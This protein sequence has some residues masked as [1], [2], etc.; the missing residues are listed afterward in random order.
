M[1]GTSE[2][3]SPVGCDLFL[4][5][6]RQYFLLL[7]STS[8]ASAMLNLLILQWP[9]FQCCRVVSGGQCAESLLRFVQ[10][11]LQWL[12]FTLV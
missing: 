8:S 4:A 3:I 9:L 2:G 1:E 11:W 10:V 5:D 7:G 12:L 6:N